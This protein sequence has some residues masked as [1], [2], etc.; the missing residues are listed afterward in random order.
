MVKTFAMRGGIAHRRPGSY[1][2]SMDDLLGPRAQRFFGDGFRRVE[3]AIGDVV[4]TSVEGAGSAR[5]TAALDY[6]ADWSKKSGSGELVPHLSTVDA[7]VLAVQLCEIY[8]GHAYGLEAEQRS[9]IWVRSASIKAG[10]NPQEDLGVCPMRLRHI[11]AEVV[12]DSLCGMVSTFECTVGTLKVRL[13]LEHDAGHPV[14]GPG[15]YDTAE[16][17]LGPAGLR[18]Y[19]DGYKLRSHALTDVVIED[20]QRG[21]SGL[22]GCE[23][24]GD[25]QSRVGLAAAY[26]PFLSPID[27]IIVG[28]QFAQALMYSVDG[29][30]RGG[31]QTLWMRSIAFQAQTPHQ[32][33]IHP[34]Q[35]RAG[36]VD[37][38]QL[39]MGNA[40]WR[41]AT[42]T[43]FLQ[44]VRV[45]AALA[46]ALT[47]FTEGK[48]S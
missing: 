8:L 24:N 32:P 41:L 35:T 37:T 22:I 38:K 30:E 31:T 10:T 20:E 16:S 46:H 2:E 12:S 1:F 48:P 23:L 9:R 4:V 7:Y 44:G 34:F 28:A 27:C 14:T 6:P 26:Q 3:H 19:G 39:M 17:V 42:L 29:I 33:V 18:H 45:T 21:I 11:G 13:L 5:A 43:G 25:D 47:P 40:V 36:V 15:F